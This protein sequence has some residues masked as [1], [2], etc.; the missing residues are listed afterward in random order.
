[1]TFPFESTKDIE[2][3]DPFL[4]PDIPLPDGDIPTAITTVAETYARM[5]LEDLE[6]DSDGICTRNPD[7]NDMWSRILEMALRE[8][9]ASSGSGAIRPN[10]ERTAA[11]LIRRGVPSSSVKATYQSVTVTLPCGKYRIYRE[12]SG[13][14]TGAFR[15]LCPRD[16]GILRPGVSSEAL[17]ELILAI[18]EAMPRVTEVTERM[19]EGVRDAETRR[20]ARLKAEQIEQTTVRR[21]LEETLV[22]MDIDCGFEVRDGI[23]RLSLSRTLKGSVEI[24]IEQLGAFLSDSARVESTLTPE[25]AEAPA[26]F[27]RGTGRSRHFFP[28]TPGK[29]WIL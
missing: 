12:T 29:G 26:A 11:A 15:I 17:A 6:A 23:V 19:R 20:M 8:A 3:C 2:Q 9:P 7:W 18:E 25:K 28:G 4:Q 21:L 24:P 14:G 22:P 16:S 5:F 13:F 27:V 1:M 10:A